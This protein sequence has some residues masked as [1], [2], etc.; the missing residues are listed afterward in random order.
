MSKYARG[1]KTSNSIPIPEG[2]T[3]GDMIK[4][5]FPKHEIE[6]LLSIGG[7]NKSWYGVTL[8]GNTEGLVFESNW[9]NAPYKREEQSE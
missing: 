4:A 3:N 6:L 1:T 7:N 2:A 8:E 9:W 5:M